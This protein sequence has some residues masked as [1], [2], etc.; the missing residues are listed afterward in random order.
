MGRKKTIADSAL[1][2]VAR[3]VFVERGFGASTREIAKRAGVSE[4]VL[5]Q[6]YSTKADLFFAAMVLPPADVQRLFQKRRRD[7][8]MPAVIEK[9][10][11]ELLDYFRRTIPVL[12]P[13][14]MHP[15]FRFEEFGRRHPDSPM[16]ALRRDLMGFLAVQRQEGR[17]GDIDPGGA[18]LLLIAT[19]HSI[20]FFER[21]GAHEGRFP[22]E[23][24][25]RTVRCLWQGLAPGAGRS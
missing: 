21:L 23:I 22:P 1:L 3:E 8:D 6:R 15:A 12:L 24:V 19:A 10:T 2:A 13:L 11:L 20:A 18:A 9:I 5:F 4:G 16:L 25:R 17:I 7:P 14:M